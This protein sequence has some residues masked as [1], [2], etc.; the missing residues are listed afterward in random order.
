MSSVSGLN[1]RP[2]SAMRLS[3]SEPRCFLSFPITRRFWSSFTS[4]TEVSS[5]KW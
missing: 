2:S 3:S 5:W 4:I 1:A